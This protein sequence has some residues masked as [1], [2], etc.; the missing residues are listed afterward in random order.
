M[1][2]N[3]LAIEALNELVALAKQQLY[4]ERDEDGAK[5]TPTE[6]HKIRE[7]IAH[8]EHS[9]HVLRVTS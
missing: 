8:L 4:S 2:I 6:Q 5:L 1:T 7:M 3:N 9:I